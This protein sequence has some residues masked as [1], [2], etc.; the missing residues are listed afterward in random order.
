MSLAS[1][2]HCRQTNVLPCYKKDKGKKTKKAVGGEEEG[3]GS[4]LETDEWTDGRIGECESLRV[5]DR[6]QGGSHSGL[7]GST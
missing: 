7:T 2:T 6:L 1:K 4:R 5:L 3:G